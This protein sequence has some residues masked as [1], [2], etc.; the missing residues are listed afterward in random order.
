MR[1]ALNETGRSIFYSLCE[2]YPVLINILADSFFFLSSN[3]LGCNFAAARGV[4]DPALWA[5]KVGNSWRTTD[6]INDSWARSG[7]R[8]L[9]VL[10]FLSSTTCGV[11][12]RTSTLLVEHISLN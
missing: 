5:G 7:S 3:L 10:F 11:E 9:C 2:W 12:I 8:H 1:D 6:D 4:D